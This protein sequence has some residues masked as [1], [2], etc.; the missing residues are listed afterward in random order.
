M[1]RGLWWAR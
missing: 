1:C